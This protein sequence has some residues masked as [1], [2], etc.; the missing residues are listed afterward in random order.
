M[1]ANVKRETECIDIPRTSGEHFQYACKGVKMAVGSTVVL[2]WRGAKSAYGAV[3]DWI[4]K[5]RDGRKG[6]EDAAEN[7]EGVE[8]VENV[9]K[10]E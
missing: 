1:E 10:A 2:A 6:K 5:A 4:R 3:S 9:E 8:E 7:V